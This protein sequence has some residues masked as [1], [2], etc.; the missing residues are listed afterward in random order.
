MVWHGYLPDARPGQLYAYRVHGPY[1]PNAGL[2]FI[3]AH[4]G[5]TFHDL[6]SY[7]EKH[8]EANDENN[9]DG[10]SHNL[11]WNCGA[12]GETNDPAVLQLREQEKRN[13]MASLLLSMGVPM[14][15]GGDEIGRTQRGNNNAYCQDNEL[16]WTNWN[17]SLEQ[18]Q[19]LAFTRR[20]VRF[21]RSQPVLS[22][23][24][25]F[26]GRPIRGAEVKDIYW[27][28][29]SGREMTDEAWN[30]PS[31]RSLGVLMVGDALDEVDERGRPV[32]GD[33]L[34]ITL[35]ADHKEV[36]FALPSI[37]PHTAWVRFLDTIAAYTEER[38]YRGAV[39]YPL[40]GRSLALFV[41]RAE[42]Q[43]RPISTEPRR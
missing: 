20:F 10:E 29:P 33:T 31:V 39:T 13:L 2:N 30:A 26:Q 36:A 14:F 5:F 40:Q 17:L 34:L 27:L 38:C 9:Q 22:R 42:P 21:R 25:Y 37:G 8:N 15:S 7:N 19:F 32:R 18:Q 24:K 43:E 28:D 41:L 23:R 12:E 4:D 16:S 3:T 6:V 1:D 11:S 35:N